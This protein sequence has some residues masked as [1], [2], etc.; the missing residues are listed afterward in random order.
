MMVPS[1]RFV[2][3]AIAFQSEI[4]TLSRPALPDVIATRRHKRSNCSA[5][6]LVPDI[7]P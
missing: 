5:M 3:R 7:P 4:L 6:G 1:F 2:S